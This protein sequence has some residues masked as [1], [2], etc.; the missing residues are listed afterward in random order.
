M[1]RADVPAYD[2]SPQHATL[3]QPIEQLECLVVGHRPQS[4]TPER[5]SGSVPATRGIPLRC[6]A[7]FSRDVG[8]IDDP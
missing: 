6:G 8:D 3:D 7:A 2:S 1:L 5:A 4:R